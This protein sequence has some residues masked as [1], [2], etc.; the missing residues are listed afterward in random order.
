VPGTGALTNTTNDGG[1]NGDFRFY[2]KGH[3][4]FWDTHS[5]LIINGKTYKLAATLKNLRS[6]IRHDPDGFYALAK[7]ANAKGIQYS[8]SPIPAFGGILD[9]LGNTI[10]DIV[11]SDS[12]DLHDVG[13]IGEIIDLN[14]AV[15]DLDLKNI[16]VSGSGASQRVGGVVGDAFSRFG[17]VVNCS[18][19]GSVSATGS[20]SRVGGVAGA[21]NGTII[22]SQSA[23]TI[24][25]GTNARAAGG[26]AGQNDGVV[27]ESFSTGIVTAGDSVVAGSLVGYNLGG[28][29]DESF[30]MGA[31]SGSGNASVGGL[32][33][34]SADNPDSGTAP[35]ISTSY[36][37]GSVSAGSGSS[38]GGSVG[39][40][41]SDSANSKTYWNLDTSGVSNPHQGAGNIPDDPG[42]T[43]LTD[44]QLKSGLPAGFDPKIWAI[45][46]KINNG[47]PYLIANPSP[48]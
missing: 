17:S 47:Y 36:S 14:A 35:Q 29:I 16:S 42:I 43:G 23:A 9:G 10:S 30:S 4:E 44:A 31:V 48:K 8:S 40:D 15:R 11:I 6:L 26:V 7:N 37:M 39:T 19:T 38:V 24:V 33:G 32:V 25:A 21:S 1:S 22:G 34:L 20:E 3:V 13:L 18:V 28:E 46:P 5:S 27:D 45:N 12:A 41:A 2:G